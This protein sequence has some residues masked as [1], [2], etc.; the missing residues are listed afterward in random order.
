MSPEVL[1]FLILLDLAL[2]HAP[3]SIRARIVQHPVLDVIRNTGAPKPPAPEAAPVAEPEV[4]PAPVADP[5]A[6]EKPAKAG[7]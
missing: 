1:S 2:E 5:A 7:K 4:P 6:P 3:Q